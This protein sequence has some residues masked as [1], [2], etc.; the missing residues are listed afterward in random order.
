TITVNDSA[1]TDAA[2]A[3]RIR[4]ILHEL[5]GYGDVSV[6]VSSGI[7]TLRGTTL[8]ATAALQLNDLVGRV[9]GV[10]AIRN[11]VAET[12]V[13]MDRLNPAVQRFQTRMWQIAAFL[14]LAL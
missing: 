10:V 12:M 1:D 3:N 11:Q 6:T 8:D 9:E 5:E 13:V 2:I 14:P 4:D 7:V